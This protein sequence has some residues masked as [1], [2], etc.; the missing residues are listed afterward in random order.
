MMMVMMMMMIMR[1]RRRRRI[2]DGHDLVV[3]RLDDDGGEWGETDK[4]VGMSFTTC[5]R[6]LIMMI[7]FPL[8]IILNC[9]PPLS[10]M[11]TTMTRL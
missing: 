7:L 11:T 8:R 10:I 4:K 3:L 1:R 5:E 2:D 9:P 6:K